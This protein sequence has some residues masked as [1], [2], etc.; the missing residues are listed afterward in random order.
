VHAN[1]ANSLM[2]DDLLVKIYSILPK[3]PFSLKN[4]YFR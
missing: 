2:I 1:I 3:W 4:D